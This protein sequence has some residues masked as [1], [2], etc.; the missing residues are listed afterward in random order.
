MIPIPAVVYKSEFLAGY[1][2]GLD[3]T[4]A[5]IGSKDQTIS[6]IFVIPGQQG[7]TP[8]GDGLARLEKRLNDAS[9]KKGVWSSLLRSLIPRP[10]L[11]LQIPR[12]Q[13]RSFINAT[14]SL[15]KMGLSDL[16]DS[17]K[18]DLKGLNGV[19]HEL[20][21]SDVLQINEFATCGEKRIAE[22]HHKEIYP[23]WSVSRKSKLIEEW[24]E[25]RDYQR[26]FDDP[27]H[28]PDMLNLPLQLRPRQARLPENPRL[29]FDR[30]FLYFVRHNPS[31][32][33]LHIGRFHPRLL[34]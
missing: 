8:P 3:A 21:L 19:A 5:A 1:D 15:K 10:G 17:R 27:L 20:F 18:A 9:F 24:E 13:H 31:G 4:A 6:T 11:E 22:T 28:D 26:A 30:P 25:P 33:I 34:P 14:S 7:I 32:L 2:P 23:S 12:F 16:F 29:R